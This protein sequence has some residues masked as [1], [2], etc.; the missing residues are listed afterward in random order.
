MKTLTQE[1]V[2]T[3]MLAAQGLLHPAEAPATKEDILPFIQ[4][5]AYLQIDTIHA[6]HRSH[7][8]VL[9]SRLG[10]YDPTWLD[11]IHQEGQLFEYYAHALCYLPIEDYLIFRGRI[12][13]DERIGNKW[14]K[15]EAA[16]PEVIEHVRSVVKENGP[17]CS[18]DFNTPTVQ[19]GWGSI[20]QE[21][22]AL[23]RMFATG[24]M[25]IPFRVNFRR[26]YDFRERVLPSWDD[27]DALNAKAALE[28]LIL[29]AVRAL[30]VAR[31]DWVPPY[32]FLP[33]TGVPE[34]LRDLAAQGKIYPVTIEGW[35][36]AAYIN[37]EQMPL[38]ET[39][40]RGDLTPSHITFLSP[41]DPLISDRNRTRALFNFDYKMEAFTPAKDRQY[42]YFCL[43]I[44]YKG[45]L[46]GRLDPK[47]HRKR[48]LMEIKNLYLEQGVTI[49]KDLINALKATLKAFAEW[50]G[51]NELLISAAHP[52][53]LGEVL[54]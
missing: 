20:K 53:E 40:T 45:R 39:I 26:Y 41:F 4:R 34:L 10:E 47:A 17:V 49:D 25:M 46:V 11:E 22:F 6:V 28:A 13:H 36:Q 23:Q 32:Y 7:Y 48:E 50:H 33:K 21:K 31:E 52:S 16:Y 14:Q 38:L 18:S 15:W 8:L 42:G 1:E 12:L 19:T 27:A 54:L 35:E 24:E 9:W 37:P 30:G 3:A 5:M 43:P 51:M 29:K 2:R 44:L